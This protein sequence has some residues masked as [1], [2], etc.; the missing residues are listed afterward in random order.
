MVTRAN[1]PMPVGA[2]LSG[3][4][5][6]LDSVQP[7]HVPTTTQ[8]TPEEARARRETAESGRVRAWEAMRPKRFTDARMGD[9]DAE[10]HARE[11][12]GWLDT[13]ALN[14]LLHG[15]TGNGKTHAAYAVGNTAI[16]RGLSVAAWT[17]ADLMA[18]LRP[19]VND[20][21]LPALT[22]GRVT[23][24]DLVILDD[25][26]RESHSQWVNEQLHTILDQRSTGH[27]RTIITTNLTGGAVEER[28]GSPVFERIEDEAM[29][30][31][32]TGASRRQ[33]HSTW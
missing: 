23:G 28:Y 10:Q 21:D 6:R 11:V 13:D 8:E 5:A 7:V 33:A 20:P 18:R 30:V 24:F 26:G 32:F 31:R 12:G 29:I 22:F 17:V 14:L 4:R 3:F 15:D 9:L 16:E 2:A 1:T 19:N 27:R 25:L